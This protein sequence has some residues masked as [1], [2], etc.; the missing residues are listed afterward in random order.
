MNVKGYSWVGVGTD[1]FDDTVSFF[2]KVM[3]LSTV[4]V[5]ER[6]VAILKVSDGSGRQAPGSDGR[7][8]AVGWVAVT[9]A[10][11]VGRQLR[12]LRSRRSKANSLLSLAG[13]LE[14]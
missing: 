14:G 8:R 2:S 10:S 3:G 1:N 5:E 11:V 12:S 7:E 6:G 9:L 4:V 13:N